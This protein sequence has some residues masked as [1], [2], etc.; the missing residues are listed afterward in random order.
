INIIKRFLLIHL[1]YYLF[2]LRANSRNLLFLFLYIKLV[3]IS[4][5][6]G[7]WNLFGIAW[8]ISVISMYLVFLLFFIIKFIKEIK[9]YN[10]SKILL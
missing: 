6:L 5:L 10:K 8:H 9:Y 4:L 1:T 2:N 7:L 3:I